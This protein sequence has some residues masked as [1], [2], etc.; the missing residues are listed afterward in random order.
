MEAP[1]PGQRVRDAVD[2]VPAPG[3]EA[4]EAAAECRP[5]LHQLVAGFEL[6]DQ[7]VRL[8][9]P[10]RQ[11]D[12]LLQCGED[13]VPEC[14]LLGGLDLGQV[15]DDRAALAAQRLVVVDHVE[16]GIDDRGGEAGAVAVAHVAVVQVQAAGA[17]DAG[18]EV[19]LLF[20]IRDGL[21]AEE[22]LGPGVHLGRD[23]LGDAQ[24]RLLAAEGDREVAL[25]VERHGVDLAERVLAV[26]HPAVGAGKQGVG[27]VADAGL[28]RRARPGGGTGA[29]D[30]LPLQVV[31]N[32][33][34]V[35]LARARLLH[36][37]RGARNDG[38]RIE[39]ADPPT[40]AEARRPPLDALAHDPLALA[41]EPREGLQRIECRRCQ[42]VRVVLPDAVTKQQ[43]TGACPCHV[44][45]GHDV[46]RVN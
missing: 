14:G 37:E 13:L 45:R 11:T 31:G 5:D 10:R 12:V 26:E 36:G 28:H 9:R 33:R 41:V 8:D 3:V 6:L 39:E 25:I 44:L 7:H 35:E 15:E 43:P 38:G 17:E 29:L 32:L 20:P 16:R 18:G 4:D 27:D 22:A 30:P 46:L 23:V 40:V 42:H 21:P 2:V 19:E 34:A 24:E 1:V